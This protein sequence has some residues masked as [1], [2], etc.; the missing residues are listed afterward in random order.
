M[1]AWEEYMDAVLMCRNE[2]RKAKAQMEL[3]LARDVKN[4][5]KGFYSYIGQKRQAKERVP[6]LVNEKWELDTTDMEKAD[7]LN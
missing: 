6:P 5:K 1:V 3:N 7:V 2:I 4:N